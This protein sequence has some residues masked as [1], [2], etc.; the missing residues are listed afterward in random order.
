MAGVVTGV[1]TPGTVRGDQL[2]RSPLLA[3]GGAAQRPSLPG[4]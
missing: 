1:V 4:T 3:E 2:V